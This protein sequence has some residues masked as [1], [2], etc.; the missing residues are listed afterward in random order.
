MRI[1]SQFRKNF[2]EI[3]TPNSL[4]LW[5]DLPSY[6]NYRTRQSTLMESELRTGGVPSW[7]TQS[8]AWGDRS[9]VKRPQSG[10]PKRSGRWPDAKKGVGGPF[11]S[12]EAAKR[13]TEA[14]RT[15][16]RR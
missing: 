11:G 3:R 13:C 14:I 16:A 1:V 9:A 12:K 4:Q 7:K 2:H 8:V 5:R 6:T 15:V 10:V